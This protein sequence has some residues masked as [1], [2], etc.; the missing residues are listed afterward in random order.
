M[1]VRD[2]VELEVLRAVEREACVHVAGIAQCYPGVE[3]GDVAVTLDRLVARG[4]V[5]G[6]D[7]TVRRGEVRDVRLSEAGASRLAASRPDGDPH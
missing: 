7:L 2:E 3:P 6:D 4:E 5:T 1:D